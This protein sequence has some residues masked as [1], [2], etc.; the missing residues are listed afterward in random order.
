M[1]GAGEV[2]LLLEVTGELNSTIPVSLTTQD[3]SAGGGCGLYRSVVMGVA[4]IEI[5]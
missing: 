4:N 2:T 5:M 1:E 3:G